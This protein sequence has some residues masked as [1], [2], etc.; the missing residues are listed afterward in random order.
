MPP[1]AYLDLAHKKTSEFINPNEA[2]GTFNYAAAYAPIKNANQQTVAYIGIPFFANNADYERKIGPFVNT[3]INIYALVF[4]LIGV[5]AVFLA[6][7]ITEPLSFI[8]ENIKRTKLGQINKPIKWRRQDEIGVL[9]REYNKMIAEL[10]ISANKIARSEREST[11]REIA[12]QVAHE[13][14]NPLTPLKLG[15]QLLER[16]WREKD[17]D[18]EQKFERFNKSF[19]EQIDSLANIASEFSKFAKMPETKLEKFAIL[20]LIKQ[21]KSLY[22]GV[23]NVQLQVIDKST[24]DCI[25]LADHDQL[26]RAFGNLFKNAA[27]AANEAK[28]CQIQVSIRND[29]SQIFVEVHDNGIGIPAELQEKIFS[30]NFTTKTSGTGLGLAFVKQAVENAD[31]HIQFSSSPKQ[32]TSFYLTFPLASYD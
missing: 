16:S 30:P 5:L 10:E 18:F 13:I 4:V 14:K 17:P 9:V 21:S 8:Q 23:E 6:K 1:T 12:K 31:G 22:D 19:I 32:G 28:M 20:P 3:L 24:K 26:L 25:I 29:D 27:E 7:Q 2:I 15:V 11:W